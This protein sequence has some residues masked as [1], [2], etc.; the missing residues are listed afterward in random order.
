MGRLLRWFLGWLRWIRL[1]IGEWRFVMLVWAAI[2]TE[3]S[4][5]TFF[6]FVSYKEMFFNSIF[7]A[8]DIY[9]IFIIVRFLIR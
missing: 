4:W 1:G 7:L 9:T 2:T 3:S 5:K 8:L 6:Q